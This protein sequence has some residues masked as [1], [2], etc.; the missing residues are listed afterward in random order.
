M[1]FNF[2][3]QHFMT[4]YTVQNI[5][6]NSLTVDSF[7]HKILLFWINGLRTRS[8]H[9]LFVQIFVFLEN[10]WRHKESAE[11]IVLLQQ[12][13]L[14]NSS[15]A[16]FYF[17]DIR[18]YTHVQLLMLMLIFL[19]FRSK[20]FQILSYIKVILI[21]DPRTMFKVLN[22]QELSNKKKY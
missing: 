1:A 20:S 7:L 22:Q 18:I 9:F 8:F 19:K 4:F 12:I 3:A 10:F 2:R 14:S 11:E 15:D 6:Y 16:R 13:F 21:L 17:I 5:D